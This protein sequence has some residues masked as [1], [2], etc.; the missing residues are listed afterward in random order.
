MGALHVL[1]N[2]FRGYNPVIL[3]P[4]LYIPDMSTGLD[5]SG[6]NNNLTIL[7]LFTTNDT[8]KLPNTTA[9]KNACTLSGFYYYFFDYADNPRELFLSQMDHNY[10]NVVFRNDTKLICFPLG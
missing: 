1:W 10:G 3:T 2:M 5:T 9:V 4:L 7:T 8:F 6:N